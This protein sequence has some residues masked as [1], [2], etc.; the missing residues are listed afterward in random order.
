LTERCLETRWNERLSSD[1]LAESGGLMELQ[2]ENETQNV[3]MVWPCEK[4]GV[5]LNWVEK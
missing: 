1:E 2:G 3:G 4:R 5:V